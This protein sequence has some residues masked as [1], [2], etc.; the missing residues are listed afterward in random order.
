MIRF[1]FGRPGSGKTHSIIREIMSQT[2]DSATPVYLIVPEQQAYSAE[3]DVLSVLPSKAGRS[4]SILSFSRLCDTVADRFG[5]RTQHTVTRAMKSLLMWENLRELTGILETYSQSTSTDR[6]L[7]KKMLRVTEKFK[8]NGVTAIALERAAEKLDKASPLYGKLRDIALITA[9]YEGLIS[10]VY[11]ENPADRLL[12]AAAKIEQYAFFEGATVFIDSFTSFTA[13]E[14]AVLRMI[15]KQAEHVTISFGCD[16]RYPTEPQFE[17]MKDAVHRLTRLCEDIG[18]E[19]EDIILTE[20][21]R[22]ASLELKVLEKELWAFGLSPEQRTI[23]P[24]EARGRIQTYVCPNIYEEAHA[25]ALHILEQA[26][27]G[28][29]Y[30]KIAVVVRDTE[31][32]KGVLD[33][34]LEQY[35]IPYFL[36][37]R[38]DLNEKPAARLLLTALRCISRKWQIEDIMTLC[39]T[40]LL[41][42]D[43][44][45]L[46]YFSEYVDTWH[47]SGKRLLESN[48]SM[49]PDGYTVDMSPRALKILQAANQV[50]EVVMNP[51]LTLEDKLRTA[52][53]VTEQCRAL[54]EYLCELDIRSKLVTQ[55]EKYLT[56]EQAREAGE[57]VRLWSFLTETLATVASV[58]QE[59]EPLTPDEL[60]TAL[61]FV[62]EDTDIGSVPAR[63]DCVTIGSADTLRV[64]HITT[65]LVL[66]L[67][68]GEFP[69]S[70][71]E[72][73]LLTEQDKETL[74]RLG[75]ELN[76]RT[77]QL[78]SDELMYVWRTFSKPSDTLILSCSSST[79]DGQTRA[80][81]AAFTRIS[82]LF[83]YIVPTAFSTSLLTL[84]KSSIHRSPVDDSISK[85]TARRLLGEEIWLSQSRLQTY[86]RCPYSYYG[87]HILRLREK[88]EAKFDNLGAGVFLHH[89]MEQYLKLTLDEHNRLRPLTEAEAMDIA[90]A[91]ISAYIENLCGDISQNGRLLHLFDRL[92]QIAF[93]LIENIQA[94][95]RQ[96]AFQVVGLEWDT[97]GRKI[98]DPQPMI[99]SLE[100][101]DDLSMLPTK[102]MVDHQ[103]IRIL[104]GG[105]IDRVDLYRGDDGETVYIRV[106]DYKSSKHEFSTKSIT[107]DMNIQLLLYLFT[108]CSPEN[109][110]LFTDEAGRLP[111]EVL[112]ASAV[113]ISPDESDRDG[114]ILP[115]RTGVVL[116]DPEILSAA[117]SDEFQS[118]LPS[119]KRNKNG[120]FTGKGL[121][122]H[123]QFIELETLLKT[124]ILD[125]ASAMYHGRVSRTPSDDACKYCRMKDSCGV[126]YRK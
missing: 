9:A 13:Q 42:I 22:T 117:N 54:Y 100:T 122:S 63:H 14:Y 46:D 60:S 86:A 71:Q 103:G 118:Y 18:V 90:N 53:S 106:I 84:E 49:N 58:M 57:Q 95:L 16:S 41:G 73:D 75:I 34:A 120:E 27:N 45:D 8:A 28:V 109:R 113:Y 21:H 87:A 78:T 47:L 43:N 35:H 121:F 61:S 38:T 68:E 50:R 82:Y 17:S 74:F 15:F 31:S 29:P 23:P 44:R 111:K 52:E 98:T 70:I 11:G 108:L 88:S 85:P 76:S 48:W 39:K 101:D 110:A 126:C 81:S 119:V 2:T 37:T 1:L 102:N 26:Q 114:V 69:R 62:F 30:D 96:S 51:L 10:Q 36:S 24:E 32:W 67:C 12:N 112:P 80:P 89:V 99:L 65:M 77:A 5:G 3:R 66:G 55:A 59:A 107:E 115:C 94:E 56:L 104:L 97:H 7:C 40:G 20:I 6:A 92:R 33:A 25:A 19:F 93:V 79:P 123:E 124:T 72:D 4:F 91:I 83:P 64:D 105:R 125:T 116:G